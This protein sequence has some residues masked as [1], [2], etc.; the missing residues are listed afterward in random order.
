MITPTRDLWAYSY[1]LTR[2]QTRGRLREIRALIEKVRADAPLQEGAWEGRLVVD[3][4]TAQI[5]ILSDSP[6]VDRA[7]N[8]R[9]E[10]ELRALDAGF[11]VS[12]PML[13][14]PVPPVPTAKD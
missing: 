11:A 6:D 5:L 1:R 4:S 7:L 3:T 13:V 14:S 12:V 8:R 2:P 10:A 9:I